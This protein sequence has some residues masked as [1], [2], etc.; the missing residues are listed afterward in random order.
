LA[1]IDKRALLEV[2]EIQTNLVWSAQTINMQ[3][4]LAISKI[5][6]IC[7]WEY[8]QWLHS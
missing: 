2:F 6:E 5:V 3:M 1:L 4:Q 7:G 8:W